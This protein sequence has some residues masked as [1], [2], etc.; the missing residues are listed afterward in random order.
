MA[1]KKQGDDSQ[2]N[3]LEARTSTAPCVPAIRKAVAAWREN[4]Y[5]GATATTKTLLTHWFAR[6]GH[7]MPGNRRFSYHY[8][9]QEAIE[10]LIYLYEAA[11][12]RRQNTLIETFARP[13]DAAQLKNLLRY[14]DFPR[15][16]LKM[17]TGSGK[18]KV[19]SL[20][21]V[22]QYFNAILEDDKEYA[23]TFLLLA[24]NIIVYERLLTDFGDGRIFRTDPLIPKELSPRWNDFAVYAR[25]DAERAHSDGALYVTNVQQL[26]RRT[27]GDSDADDENPAAIMLGPTPKMQKIETIDFVERITARQSHCFVMNDEAHHTHDE[28]LRWNEIIRELHEE[29]DDCA[30]MQLDVTA[31]PRHDKGTLFSWTIYDYP[32]KQA[33]IDNIV[34]RP[35]K[36]V[37]ANFQEVPSAIASVKYQPYLV[38]GVERW[39]E[40][41]EQL[42]PLNKKPL[43][44]VMMNDTAEADDVADFLRTK[45]PAEFADDGDKK[46]LLNIH[47]D[48]SGEVS[49]KDLD[50]A[51]KLAREADDDTNSIN[52]IVSVL[53][54]REGWDVQNVT[55]VVGLRPFNAKSNILP[56][57]TIG[58]GLRLMFRGQNTGYTE[59]VDIIGNKAF[60]QFVDALEKEENI[61]LATFEIGKDKLKI[62]TIRPD[63]EKADKDIRL[64]K[65]TPALTR[66]KTL[67]EEIEALNIAAMQCPVL[68]KKE[69]DAAAQTFRYEGHDILTLQKIVEAEYTIPEPQTAQ[70]V[71]GY[72]AKRIAQ[73]VKLP[74]QFAHLVPKVREFLEKRAFGGLTDIDTPTMIKAISSNIAAYVTIKTFT[75]ALRSVVL[76]EQTPVLESEGRALSETPPF[77]FSRETFAADKTIFNLVAPDNAF[78]LQFARFL[79]DSPD[80][81]RFAKLPS[82][83]GFVIEYTDSATSLRYYEPDFVA[84]TNDGAQYIIE[85]KGLEDIDVKFKDRAAV[86]WCENATLLTDNIWR[87]V[88]VPQKEFN[89]LNPDCL[90]D[91]LVTFGGA[92]LF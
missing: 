35:V 13:E 74:S 27:A 15:Y 42:K 71:I 84:V 85:T 72:Y 78:E 53:M 91:L 92:G 12:V 40:Y 34:K 56:E 23:K 16:C 77:P 55:V 57:Q 79:Q 75:A 67:A 11:K 89:G 22:W 17:A 59:R 62:E 36:G 4:G 69:N 70:E 41:R 45:Y 43:L 21:L 30:V 52:A 25:G 46:R 29:L 58:R 3:L 86:L 66:K 50:A 76:E 54:L 88:K 9:Q 2:M 49:K 5:P 81:V 80:V 83:F 44:F 24:P 48:K 87:F 73:D 37:A 90:S 39:R 1:R 32:L 20:A 19:M 64:P 61:A 8:S 31:T 82:Q 65:L 26:H 68:P 14:D 28:K 6:D 47:T 10:T 60:I 18:T 33:M 51:R 38:A 63:P 7:R